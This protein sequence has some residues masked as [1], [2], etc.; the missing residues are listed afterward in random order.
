MVTAWG[1]RALAG[2]SPLLLSVMPPSPPHVPGAL[3]PTEHATCQPLLFL[4]TTAQS[5]LGVVHLSGGTH[6]ARGPG[7]GPFRAQ[8]KETGSQELSGLG[9]ARSTRNRLPRPECPHWGTHTC[10]RAG[11]VYRLH[12]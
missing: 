11:H 2:A 7:A 10:V 4:K 6:S 1:G 8:Q 9:P 5:E 3:C 12:F